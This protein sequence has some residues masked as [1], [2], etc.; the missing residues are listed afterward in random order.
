M[1]KNENIKCIMAL[2]G[3]LLIIY[4]AT[5]NLKQGSMEGRWDKREVHKKHNTIVLEAVRVE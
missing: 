2:G 3:R 5:T 4:N 1:T